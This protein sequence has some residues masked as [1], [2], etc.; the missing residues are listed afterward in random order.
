[1]GISPQRRVS[2]SFPGKLLIQ[3]KKRRVRLQKLEHAPM[4]ASHCLEVVLGVPIRVVDDTGVS[5]QSKTRH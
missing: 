2:S 3:A 1:M 4:A 5:L